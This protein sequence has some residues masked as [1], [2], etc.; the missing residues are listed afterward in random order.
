MGSN[1]NFDQA[2]GVM[3]DLGYTIEDGRGVMYRS[4][5]RAAREMSDNPLSGIM[6]GIII[7]QKISA[8]T[9]A[10]CNDTF[11]AG[12]RVTYHQ[13]HDWAVKFSGT[14][15]EYTAKI[16]GEYLRIVHEDNSDDTHRCCVDLLEVIDD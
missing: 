7:A 4:I 1:C 8:V 10:I 2:V 16:N 9:L 12:T 11:P 14:C 15:T 5:R 6:A 3:R 13:P